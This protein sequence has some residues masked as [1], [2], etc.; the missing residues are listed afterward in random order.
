MY[1]LSF[2]QLSHVRAWKKLVLLSPR[3]VTHPA[4]E[5]DM[6]RFFAIDDVTLLS[7]CDLSLYSCSHYPALK[8]KLMMRRPYMQLVDQGIMPRKS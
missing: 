4:S 1:P 8:V 3:R 7:F 6:K 5:A 2:S